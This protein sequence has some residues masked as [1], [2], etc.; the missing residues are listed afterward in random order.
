MPSGQLQQRRRSAPARRK[1]PRAA[2]PILTPAMRRLVG[3]HGV[4]HVVTRAEDGTQQS[5][6]RA[7]L[8]PWDGDRLAFV[9]S[10]SS[11]T[12][13]NLRRA[14]ELDVEVVDPLRGKGYRFSGRARVVSEGMLFDIVC[15]H[16]VE[17]ELRRLVEAVVIVDVESVSP[18]IVPAVYGTPELVVHRVS[19]GYSSRKRA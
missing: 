1:K 19:A 13:A 11:R 3:D 17:P 2:S 4:A 6:P 16:Q 8:M 10:R 18:L 15:A 5:S 12:L 14:P 9:E 7:S